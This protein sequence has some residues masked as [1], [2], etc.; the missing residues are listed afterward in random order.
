MAAR[1]DFV[2]TLKQGCQIFLGTTYKKGTIIP[3]DHK[4]YHMATKI[5]NG[6]MIGHKDIKYTNI[7]H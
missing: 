6:R 1:Q 4:I 2:L 7:F 3:Y 5:P